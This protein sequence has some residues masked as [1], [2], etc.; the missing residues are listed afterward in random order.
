MSGYVVLGLAIAAEVIAT[1]ALISIKGFDKPFPLFLVV[2][3]YVVSFALLS[4][5]VRTIPVGVA[6]AIWSG[7]GIVS[8]TVVA[9]FLYQQRPDLPAIM[10]MLMIAGGV[11]VIKLGSSVSGG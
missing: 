6:Y 8:V 4:I 2:T 3:G 10:G 7:M 9:F 11:A 5:V 1:S